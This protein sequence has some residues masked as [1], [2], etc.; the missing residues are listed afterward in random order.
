MEIRNTLYVSFDCCRGTLLQGVV[1]GVVRP[2][3]GLD[4]RLVLGQ[5]PE[6]AARLHP[7]QRCPRASRRGRVDAQ[8]AQEAALSLHLPHRPAAGRRQQSLQRRALVHG[9]VTRRDQV[10]CVISNVVQGVSILIYLNG[11]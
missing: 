2:V 7:P 5:G 4:A 8:G 6:Q 9:P 10:S 3:R 11:W 1:R